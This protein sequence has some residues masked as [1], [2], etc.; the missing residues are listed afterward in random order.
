MWALCSVLL[1]KPAVSAGVDLSVLL[2]GQI[3]VQCIVSASDRLV[4]LH[5][6]GLERAQPQQCFVGVQIIPA[7]PRGY[8]MSKHAQANENL[9]ITP[10]LMHVDTQLKNKSALM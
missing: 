8:N 6:F 5:S 4:S 1:K 3:A 7:G 2:V 9:V 10:G